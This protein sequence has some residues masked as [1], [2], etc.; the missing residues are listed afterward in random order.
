MPLMMADIWAQL[1]VKAVQPEAVHHA[2]TVARIENANDAV[3]SERT[4]NIW[5]RMIC[6]PDPDRC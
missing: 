1:L 4:L 5:Q 3:F 2:V 6:L